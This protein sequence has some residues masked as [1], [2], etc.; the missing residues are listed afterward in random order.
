MEK[1]SLIKV[2]I[3]SIT[4]FLQLSYQDYKCNDIVQNYYIKIEQV[5]KLIKPVLES[6]IDADVDSNESLQKELA[7]MSQSL[8]ILRELRKDS[9]SLMSKVYSVFK[10]EL[11]FTNL[12]THCL[13]L[14]YMLQSFEGLTIESNSPLLETMKNLGYEKSFF[15]ISKAISDQLDGTKPSSD[16][17]S[18]I[19]D[20]LSLK[21][22]QELLI[23]LVALEN[24]KKKAEQGE[25]NI[26]DVEYIK[27]M[28]SIVTHIHY[29]FV[30]KLIEDLSGTSID[31]VKN[32]TSEL[33]LLSRYDN[34]IR[35]IIANCGAITIL[36]ALLHSPDRYIQENAVTTLLNLSI[37]DIVRSA[38]GDANAIEPLI[39]VLKTGSPKAKEN[40]AATLFSLAAIEDYKILI[41]QA[42]AIG[43]LVDLLKN[44]SLQGKKDAATALF[45]LSTLHG[46]KARIVEAGAVRFL[47]E[48]MNPAFGLIDKAVA[49]LGNLATISEGREDIGR[50]GCIPMLVDVVE[51]GSAR[52]KE[53][54]AAALL[55]LCTNS[56]RYCN[57]VLH[58]GAV[59]PLAVLAQSGT[60]RAKEKA[61]TLLSFF[62]NQ[63]Q[64]NGGRR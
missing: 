61:Q 52:G 20:L 3:K 26:E 21:S 57:I 23:E 39:H 43:P 46:N 7:G 36:T 25:Q 28:I 11:L 62:R 13:D 34:D 38:I 5:L 60:R 51:L 24:L 16:T 40:S 6:I 10:G 19:A 45:N 50:E 54:A 35:N 12:Q 56:N 44:G 32:A 18:K 9:R 31:T 30:K 14:V 33:R 59:P 29:S 53:N 2:F 27:G 37:N 55:H 58:E 41:G 8:D 17:M 48:L 64:G 22:N 42:G 1:I 47:V 4:N 15:I 63:R 49:V